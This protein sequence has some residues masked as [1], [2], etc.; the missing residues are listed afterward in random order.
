MYVGVIFVW[1]LEEVWMCRQILVGIRNAWKSVV[2][3]KCFAVA[4]QKTPFVLN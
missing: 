1:L 2:W 3:E 4:P